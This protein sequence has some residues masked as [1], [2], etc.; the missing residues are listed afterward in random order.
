MRYGV[1]ILAS[2]ALLWLS[3]G[4]SAQAPAGAGSG[5][6][7]YLQ[8]LAE[9]PDAAAPQSIEP[10]AQGAAKAVA[11]R[12][13][14]KVLSARRAD[15]NGRA[16]YDLTVMRAGGDFDDAYGVETLTV[17]AKTGELLP[18]F[19]NETSGYRLSAPPDRTPR[20]GAVATTIRRESFRRAETGL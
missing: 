3:P 19:R 1:L 18:Q 14:V 9:P 7:R 12:F 16:V 4:A 5:A 11:E 10:A 2:A 15:E 20:D 13:G 6:A 17:D 8:S